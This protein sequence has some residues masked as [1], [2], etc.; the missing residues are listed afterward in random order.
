MLEHIKSSRSA[1]LESNQQEQE[2]IVSRK[3]N[4]KDMWQQSLRP[5]FFRDYIGQETLRNNLS[6]YIEAAKKRKE[7]NE[8]GVNF[9]VTSG[10]AIERPGDLAALLTNLEEHDVLFIDEIHRLNRSVEEILYPAMEDFALDIVMGKGPGA[11]SYRLDLPPFT[12]VGATTRAGALAAPLRD[13]FGIVFRMQFYSP[14]ELMLIIKRA[15]T[16]LSIDIEDEGAREI[17]NRSRGTPRIANR[18]L[19]RVRDFAQVMGSGII[20][21]AIASHALLQLHVD[22]LG[23]DAIDREV[24]KTIIYKFNGGPVGVDTIAASVREERA[25]I[26]DVYEPYL[27]QIGFLSRTPRGRIATKAAYDHLGIPWNSERT[28]GLFDGD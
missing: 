13:R 7:A 24:M 28:Q 4:G 23:L 10:P 27:M 25:T 26:E 6:V 3:D 22:G 11:R 2:R 5:K 12:L 15:A 16:I 21:D 1:A 19:K 20:T 8:L 9:R 17:A 18:L 14:E